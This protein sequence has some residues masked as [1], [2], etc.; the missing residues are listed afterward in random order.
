MADALA[1]PGACIR[2]PSYS[3]RLWCG[4]DVYVSCLPETRLAH[5]RIV[6][7]RGPLIRADEAPDAERNDVRV[8]LG[9][10]WLR[11]VSMPGSTS[12]P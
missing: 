1:S 6:E 9:L 7:Q 12:M 10:T 5:A 8:L 11:V 3:V 4:C 2:F